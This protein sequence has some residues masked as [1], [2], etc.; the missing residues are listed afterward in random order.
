MG[1]FFAYITTNPRKTVLYAGMTNDLEQRLTEHYLNRGNPKT[2]AG[3]YYCYFLLHYERF[4]TP[5]KA[6]ERKEKMR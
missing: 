3:R 2:F 4:Q 5:S 6:I 1:N